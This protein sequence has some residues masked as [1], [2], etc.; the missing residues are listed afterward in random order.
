MPFGVDVQHVDR[1]TASSCNAS[2]VTAG[3]SICRT[4]SACTWLRARVGSSVDN[5]AA[6]G[7][8]VTSYMITVPSCVVTAA[9][10]NRNRSSSPRRRVSSANIDGRGSTRTPRHCGWRSI[11]VAKVSPSRPLC[12]PICTKNTSGWRD[13]QCCQMVPGS[14]STG[15]PASRTARSRVVTMLGTVDRS[16]S[17]RARY[18][19]DYEAGRDRR[20]DRSPDT[21]PHHNRRTQQPRATPPASRRGF[22]RVRLLL[23]ADRVPVRSHRHR[24]LRCRHRTRCR[25]HPGWGHATEDRLTEGLPERA[26]TRRRHG[27]RRILRGPV[28]R[29]ARALT[30]DRAVPLR[31]SVAGH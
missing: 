18:P 24:E 11:H 26:P 1:G 5:I 15:R 30:V 21:Q 16:C 29:E 27:G 6:S 13:A 14:V 25:D 31:P 23:A 28:H 4:C 17:R 2:Q 12:E 7:L 22:R 8:P 3:T 19:S 20:A 10:T 9:C